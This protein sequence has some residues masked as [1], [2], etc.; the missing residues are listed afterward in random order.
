MLFS[1]SSSNCRKL[2]YFLYDP[3]QGHAHLFMNER[4]L[5]H[6]LA[7]IHKKQR[8]SLT[9]IFQPLMER[10]LLQAIGFAQQALYPVPVYCA[11]EFFGAHGETCLQGGFRLLACGLVGKPDHP[12]G[13]KRKGLSLFEQLPDQFAALQPFV[14]P[15]CI[16]R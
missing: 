7:G 8:Q 2:S 5:G 11:V 9:G 4:L 16:T 6:L 13:I 14:F 12:Q 10:M 15:K 1:G 3:V